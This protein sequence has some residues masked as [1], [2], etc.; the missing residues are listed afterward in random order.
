MTGY[1]PNT[2]DETTLEDFQFADNYFKGPLPASLG[3]A[4]FLKNMHA[5]RNQLTGSLPESFY[6]LGSLK[7]LYLDENEMVGELPQT[8][9]PFY[10]RLQEL[11]IHSNGFSGRFPVEHFESMEVLSEHIDF[12]I[13]E[14]HFVFEF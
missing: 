3:N 1:L 5:S 13:Y 8:A 4:K 7:E 10:D 6:N 11:S 12:F 2:W 14:V 9:V